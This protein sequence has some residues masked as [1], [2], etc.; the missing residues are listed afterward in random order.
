[1]YSITESRPAI[2]DNQEFLRK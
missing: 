1:M 2:S